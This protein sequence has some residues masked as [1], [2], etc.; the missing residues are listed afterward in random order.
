MLVLLAVSVDT[1]R[2]SPARR[3][4][5]SRLL[6]SLRYISPPQQQRQQQRRTV[7]LSSVAMTSPLR[8]DVTVILKAVEID[9]KRSRA[10]M[11]R[12]KVAHTRLPSVWFR[13]RSRFM[14]V[15]L[16]VT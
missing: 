16:P 14:T 4:R 11:R 9:G 2:R 3:C 10:S 13:S 15:S 6:R 1:P 7:G 5:G 8:T 12:L